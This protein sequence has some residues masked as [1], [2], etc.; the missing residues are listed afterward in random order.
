MSKSLGNFFTVR[1]L[2]DQGVAGEVIRFVFLSTHY[3]KPMDWTEKKRQEAES[4]LLRWKDLIDQDRDAVIPAMQDAE[5]P[6]DLV[7]AIA[8]DLNTSQAITHLHDFAKK[9]RSGLDGK[10]QLAMGLRF[11]GFDPERDWS[12]TFGSSLQKILSDPV[13]LE[14]YE[15]LLWGLRQDA[16]DSKDF[17]EVDRVKTLL[18]EA[19]LEVRISKEGVELDFK[20]TFD[21]TK[22]EGLLA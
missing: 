14:P 19:G 13:S 18:I 1:D 5:F 8:A 15:D 20:D 6:S 22:L 2:L 4:T 17:S 12:V 10:V 3:S 16:M 7:A 9:A 21:A 11:L